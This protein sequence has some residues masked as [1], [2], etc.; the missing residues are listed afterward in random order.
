MNEQR[1]PRAG[2]EEFLEVLVGREPPG[3]FLEIRSRRRG[4][5]SQL[6]QHWHHTADTHNAALAIE[7]L[8][9]QGD[10]Y[11]GVAPRHSRH[12]GKTAITHSWVLWADL[13]TSTRSESVEKLPVA[14]GI[15]IASG[16]SGHQHLYWPLTEPVDVKGAERA[17]AALARAIGADSGAVLNAATILRPPGALNYKYRPP[18]AVRLERFDPT[19][20]AI[21]AIL[22]GLPR[23][24]PPRRRGTP[25][26]SDAS[27]DPLLMIAPAVYVEVL[28]GLC[29]PRSRKV[30]C[31]FH[32]DRT[33]SLHVYPTAVEGW[34][35]F[36]CGRGGTIIDLAAHL[37]GLD[38]RGS[39]YY[40]LRTRLRHLFPAGEP[41]REIGVRG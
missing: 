32:T 40:E 4:N 18:A 1:S 37:W 33:P 29:V 7:R 11:V 5:P 6:Q 23:A 41:L 3:S 39:D 19:A 38:T 8:A 35:C 30:S 16:S 15:I 9:A 17:T 10:V 36:G 12:G 20:H 22:A 27:C 21:A 26:A 13:D 31:P 2:L 24:E 14:P 28:T 25:R 34:C